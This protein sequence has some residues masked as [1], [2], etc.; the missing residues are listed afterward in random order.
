MPLNGRYQLRRVRTPDPEEPVVL[1]FKWRPLLGHSGR[2]AGVVLVA[3]V[4]AVFGLNG[5]FDHR[6]VTAPGQEPSFG[7]TSTNVQFL[8]QSSRSKLKLKSIFS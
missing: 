3:V 6:R 2:L 5:S 1:C 7:S 8:G 4:D